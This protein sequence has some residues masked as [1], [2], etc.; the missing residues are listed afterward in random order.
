MLD[1]L[2]HRHPVISVD[3]QD[4]LITKLLAKKKINGKIIL[5]C[6]SELSSVAFDYDGEH[7]VMKYRDT[8]VRL[9]NAGAQKYIRAFRE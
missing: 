1:E 6:E 8:F 7:V 4:G 2:R 5:K 3:R 9:T